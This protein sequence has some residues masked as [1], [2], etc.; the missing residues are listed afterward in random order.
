VDEVL[1]CHAVV[2]VDLGASPGH[3]PVARHVIEKILAEFESRYA[4]RHYVFQTWRRQD[5]S[6]MI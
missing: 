4:V 2:E 5:V 6:D 3:Y 1:S